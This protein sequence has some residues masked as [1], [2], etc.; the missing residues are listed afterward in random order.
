[1]QV[2]LIIRD[3]QMEVLR[4][5]RRQQLTSELAAYLRGPYRAACAA[6]DDVVL[7][8]LIA[9]G[10]ARAEARG[11]RIEHNQT[12]FIVLMVILGRD[13]DRDGRH[14]WASALLDD[15]R[16]D[17]DACMKLVWAEAVTRLAPAGGTP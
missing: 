2:V 14:P 6:L 3:A 8:A 17:G 13:F 7:A 9:E 11:I 4:Q 5:K 15:A 10:F 16:L 12:R 1:M